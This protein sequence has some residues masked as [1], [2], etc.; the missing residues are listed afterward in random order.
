MILFTVFGLGGVPAPPP[1]RQSSASSWH[2][3][4]KCPCSRFIWIYAR[5]TMHWTWSDVSR[6]YEGMEL[7]T[8][9]S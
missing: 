3:C 7:A 9:S 5:H 6:S 4:S 2:P 1:P 8:G